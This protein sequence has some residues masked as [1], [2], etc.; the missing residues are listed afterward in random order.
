MAHELGAARHRVRGILDTL[1]ATPHVVAE[2]DRDNARAG[3]SDA[4]EWAA[5]A[6]DKRSV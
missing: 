2:L 4:L 3:L 5:R 1:N 6:A